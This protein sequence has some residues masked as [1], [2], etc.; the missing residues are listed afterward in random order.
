[1]AQTKYC[2]YFQ[3]V[4]VTQQYDTDQMLH[5]I[6]KKPRLQQPREKVTEMP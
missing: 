4:I 1:M 6:K 3:F 2:I 5:E